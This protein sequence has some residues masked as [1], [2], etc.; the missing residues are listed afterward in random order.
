MDRRKFLSLFGPTLGGVA[1][2]PAIPL[3]RVWSFPRKL[4]IGPQIPHGWTLGDDGLLCFGGMSHF[5]VY[6]PCGGLYHAHLRYRLKERRFIAE[7]VRWDGR[8]IATGPL[9]VQTN[10]FAGFTSES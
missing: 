9:V 1:L 3:G 2:A 5:A 4:V 8:M 7:V 10:P 6:R